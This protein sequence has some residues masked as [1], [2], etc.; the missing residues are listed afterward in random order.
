MPTVVEQESA[1]AGMPMLLRTLKTYEIHLSFNII[2]LTQMDKHNI[3]VKIDFGQRESIVVEGCPVRT[4]TVVI[5]IIVIPFPFVV[6]SC[7]WH[8]Q[9]TNQQKQ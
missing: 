7:L 3:K 9:Q 4:T 2:V 6:P 1:K 8:S 5:I